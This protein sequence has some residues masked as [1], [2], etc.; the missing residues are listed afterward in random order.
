MTC[1][2]TRFRS[3]PSFTRTWTA[4]P[5]PS[6]IRPRDLTPDLGHAKSR[7]SLKEARRSDGGEEDVLRGVPPGCGGAVP[8][9]AGGDGGGHRRGPGDHG[10]DVVG[11]VEGRRGGGVPAPCWPVRAANTGR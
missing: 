4:T 6:W 7:L 8:D 2:R 3:A 11:V 10:L 1:W 9:D 5:S